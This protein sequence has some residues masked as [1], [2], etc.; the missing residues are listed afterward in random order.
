[1]RSRPAPPILSAHPQSK[2]ENGFCDIRFPSPFFLFHCDARILGRFAL[3]LPRLQQKGA[4]IEYFPLHPKKN[5]QKEFWDTSGKGSAVVNPHA[6]RS[7]AHSGASKKAPPAL[8]AAE[9][10]EVSTLR[11]VGAAD[12]SESKAGGKGGS[13]Q[14]EGTPRR[15]SACEGRQ[16]LGAC[17]LVRNAAGLTR[18]QPGVKLPRRGSL[19]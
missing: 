19:P 12:G 15:A 16:R 6:V 2:K 18:V 3:R 9:G 7:A 8:I 1:M 4:V 10:E 11:R 13:E 17:V 5:I 14:V